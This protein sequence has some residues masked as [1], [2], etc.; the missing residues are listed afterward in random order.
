M[1]NFT[2]TNE[3]ALWYISNF[4][5]CI[6]GVL[7]MCVLCARSR[8][9][10]VSSS[11]RIHAPQIHKINF[12]KRNQSKTTDSIVN[13]TTTTAPQFHNNISQYWGNIASHH[14]HKHIFIY[15]HTRIFIVQTMAWHC[16]SGKSI[17]WS[18]ICLMILANICK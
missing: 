14:K 13:K 15:I 7:Y 5:E 18:S 8:I 16:M 12:G 1:A 4:R 9:E 10:G 11:N 17:V 6:C 2:Y 3:K